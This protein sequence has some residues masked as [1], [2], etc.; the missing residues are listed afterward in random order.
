MR[1]EF[2]GYRAH[3]AVETQEDVPAH[4]EAR[5]A[6]VRDFFRAQFNEGARRVEQHAREHCEMFAAALI[7]EAHR[8]L[9]SAE[10]SSAYRQARVQEEL[11]RARHGEEQS[12]GLWRI[13]MANAHAQAAAEQEAAVARCRF[14][15][16]AALDNERAHAE[17][18][19]ELLEEGFV[20]ERDRAAVLAHKGA[21][22]REEQAMVSEF[23][24][25]ALGMQARVDEFVEQH[26]ESTKR[27]ID[28]ECSDVKKHER[29][30]VEN[31]EA[32]AMSSAPANEFNS[33]NMSNEV[34]YKSCSLHTSIF[35]ASNVIIVYVLIRTREVQPI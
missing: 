24:D 1:E 26:A 2:D 35:S 13:E 17:N 10:G 11:V 29:D 22:L 30:L 31:A 20:R 18:R 23:Q 8:E 3:I 19:C 16:A 28:R 25:T 33:A 7:E 21:Q 4:V 14:L 32:L 34:C 6:E 9:I 15:A 27:V 12:A 5:I